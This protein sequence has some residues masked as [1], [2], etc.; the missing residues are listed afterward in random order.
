MSIPKQYVDQRFDCASK[1]L[2]TVY[3]L[4]LKLIWFET[5]LVFAEEI[6]HEKT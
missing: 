3:S 4:S 1:T 5:K 2:D 6:Y